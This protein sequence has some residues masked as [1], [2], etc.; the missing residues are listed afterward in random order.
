MWP[1]ASFARRRS[2][3]LLRPERVPRLMC[4]ARERAADGVPDHLWA[5]P[6]ANRAILWNWDGRPR[7]KG[8]PLRQDSIRRGDTQLLSGLNRRRSVDCQ[9][10]RG[11]DNVAGAH[12]SGSVATAERGPIWLA[13]RN[14]KNAQVA[15]FYAKQRRGEARRK[16]GYRRWGVV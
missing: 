8:Q 5:G 4:H 7:Q 15:E 14:G 11:E 6:T 13:A 12:D 2:G 3:P 1:V 9:P 10:A 16:C